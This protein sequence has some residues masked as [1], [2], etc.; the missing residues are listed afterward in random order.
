MQEDKKEPV[1][2]TSIVYIS[3]CFVGSD[4]TAHAFDSLVE[5][6]NEKKPDVILFGGNLFG[7]HTNEV[8]I[9]K[10]LASMKRKKKS[11]VQVC[12]CFW[13]RVQ[14][15]IMGFNL[16]AAVQM[17]KRKSPCHIPYL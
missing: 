13:M 17:A 8:T 9:D 10:T 4:M 11:P 12:I 3:N 14:F 5:K 15:Y 16:L 2:D 1:K 6:V 7:R